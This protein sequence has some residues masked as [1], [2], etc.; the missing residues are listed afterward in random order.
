MFPSVLGVGEPGASGRQSTEGQR[1]LY[2]ENLS[3]QRVSQG[4]GHIM[5]W[6][7]EGPVDR[8]WR[9]LGCVCKAG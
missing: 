4:S 2:G 7:L 5:G 8:V 3:A 1:E 6:L 9:W